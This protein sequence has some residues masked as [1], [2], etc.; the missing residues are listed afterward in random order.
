MAVSVKGTMF[1]GVRG[2][3]VEFG[4]FTLNPDTINTNA[5]AE[6]TLTLAGV[7]SGDLVFVNPRSLDT[8]L[9]AK[10]ARVT[11]TDE[12]GVRIANVSAASVNGGEV[13]YDYQVFKF[14]GN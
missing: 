11:A 14:H 10:G 8:S 12:I 2:G 9:V 1:D 5:E 4:T 6:T 7:K 13:T 3:D